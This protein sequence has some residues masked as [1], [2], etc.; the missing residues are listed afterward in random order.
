MKS[1]ILLATL[2]APLLVSAA[3]NV[4]GIEGPINTNTPTP[5]SIAPYLPTATPLPDEIDGVLANGSVVNAPKWTAPSNPPIFADSHDYDHSAYCK[6]YIVQNG[7]G[8][9]AQYQAW[10]RDASNT[11]IGGMP[12]TLI[13]TTATI[14]VGG[15]KFSIGQTLN[16]D[17]QSVPAK[18]SMTWHSWPGWNV[19]PVGMLFNPAMAGFGPDTCTFDGNSGPD[20]TTTYFSC[21]FACGPEGQMQQPP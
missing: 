15:G 11:P 14:T 12:T 4:A 17:G 20:G 2:S 8:S 6:V 13:G 19:Q 1:Y 21:A 3:P 5:I 16:M 9:P 10:F 18:V 7:F